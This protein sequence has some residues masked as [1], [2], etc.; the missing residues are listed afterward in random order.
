MIISENLLVIRRGFKILYTNKISHLIL[1]RLMSMVER[2]FLLMVSLVWV[3]KA[4]LLQSND[5]SV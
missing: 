1:S 4:F 3:V 2:S 5:L